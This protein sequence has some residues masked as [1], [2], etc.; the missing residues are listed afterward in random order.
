MHFLKE[1]YF[2]ISS[3]LFVEVKVQNRVISCKGYTR[4]KQAYQCLT[5]SK[6][7]RDKIVVSKQRFYA[8]NVSQT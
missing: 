7:N 5:E 1:I 2:L 4:T 3:I 6:Q 8:P